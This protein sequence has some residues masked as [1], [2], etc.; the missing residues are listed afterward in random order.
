[1]D[2]FHEA[3]AVCD[4][5]AKLQASTKSVISQVKFKSMKK[6]NCYKCGAIATSKEHVPPKC[7]FPEQKDI[8]GI[9]LRKN[10]ITVPS[11]NIHNQEKSHDDEFLMVSL[12]GVIG[13]NSIGYMHKF[14]KVDRAIR[15]TSQKLINKA[16]LKQKRYIYKKNNEFLEIIWGTPDYKRLLNSFEMIAYGVHLDYFLKPFKG[17]TKVMLGYLFHGDESSKNLVEFLK[18]K[19]KI[20]LKN[21]EKLGENKNVFFYQFSDIDEFG[22]Y[23]LR[24]CFYGGINIYV[25]FIPDGIELPK[26]LGY[27]LMKKGIHTIFTVE[28]KEYE[29]NKS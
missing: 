9:D 20:D 7:I 18:H 19:A 5:K 22:I 2:Q 3:L 25:S 12:A 23:M 4:A 17:K 26:H 10:L 24:L 21:K 1:M 28:G 15:R 8:R 11:C 29:V 27:E 6:Q 13:N 14:T 16:F